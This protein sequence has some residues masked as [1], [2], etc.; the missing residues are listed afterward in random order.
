VPELWAAVWP[1]DARFPTISGTV[2]YLE[3]WHDWVALLVVGVLVWAAMHAV[4]F[5]RRAQY[6][7]SPRHT[8]LGRYTLAEPKQPFS[9]GVAIRRSL[10]LRIGRSLGLLFVRRTIVAMSAR[11]V[12]LRSGAKTSG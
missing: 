7:R 3:Y 6:V 9:G 2:G 1:D 4:R 8:D 11:G 5:R 12:S 10:P